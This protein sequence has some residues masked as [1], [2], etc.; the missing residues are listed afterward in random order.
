MEM[1]KVESWSITLVDDEN[2]PTF[3]YNHQTD[4]FQR[5]PK[6]PCLFLAKTDA[7]KKF[8]ELNNSYLEI[9]GG[10]VEIP[11]EGLIETITEAFLGRREE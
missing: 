6:M 7:D 5:E 11:K 8:L 9:V 10:F 4:T 3:F 2:Q 1:V